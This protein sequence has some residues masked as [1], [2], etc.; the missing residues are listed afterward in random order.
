[1]QAAYLEEAEMARMFKHINPLCIL[2]AEMDAEVC[3]AIGNAIAGEPA[4]RLMSVCSSKREAIQFVH[5][6]ALD[7]ALVGL[8][9]SDGSGLEVVQAVRCRQPT[10]D[11]LVIGPAYDK[12]AILSSMEGGATGFLCKEALLRPKLA[13]AIP[14]FARLAFARTRNRLSTGEITSVQVESSD[15]SNTQRQILHCLLRGLSNKEIA[16]DL[17]LTSYNVDYHLKCLRKR[18]LVRNRVQLVGAARA[19][20]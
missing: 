15:L 4:F 6:R 14:V 17:T 19:L 5:E 20:L 8:R 11:A 2:L 18:F 3:A 12:E 13:D 7:I 1:M 9:L 16:R 10:A